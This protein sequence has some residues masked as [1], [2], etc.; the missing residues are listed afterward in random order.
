MAYVTTSGNKEANFIAK[1]V[2]SNR[3]AACVNLFESKGSIY[4]WQGSLCQTEETIMIAKLLKTNYPKF[5]ETVKKLHSYET[6]CIVMIPISD[7]EKNFLSW[8]KEMTTVG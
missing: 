3:L 2:V 5:E 7:G 4:M 1:E 6:P 8:I